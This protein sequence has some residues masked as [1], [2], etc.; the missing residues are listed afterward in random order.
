[1]LS[2]DE[3]IEGLLDLVAFMDVGENNDV[4]ELLS[5]DIQDMS[6]LMEA[7]LE[8]V[9]SFRSPIALYPSTI[10][11]LKTELEEDR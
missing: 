2:D 6:K 5:Q 8:K 7:M 11:L 4:V 1:M 10:K 9:L 3:W